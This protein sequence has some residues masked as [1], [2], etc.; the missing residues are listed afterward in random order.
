MN[1]RLALLATVDP[2]VTESEAFRLA[3]QQAVTE[4]GGWGGT[5]HLR[6]HRT[7]LRLVSTTGLPAEVTR[8]WEIIDPE[9]PAAPARAVRRG[10]GVWVPAGSAEPW[11]GTGLA[12][13]PLLS[14]GQAVG[15]LTVLTGEGAEPTPEHW[16]FLRATATWAQERMTGAP[17]PAGPRPAGPRGSRL[18]EALNEVRVGAWEWDIRT[19]ELSLDEAA[20]A[21]FG[22][23]T[24]STVPPVESW[25]R[26]VHP[27]DLPST[28]AVLEK[29]ITDGSLYEVEYRARRPDGGYGWTR[30]R[31]KVVPDR[32][33]EPVRMVGTVWDTT[34]SRSVRDTLSR[35]LRHMSDGFLA[36]DDDWQIVF[37]NREAERTLGSPEEELTGRTLW[38]L[39]AVRRVPD[40]ERRCREA[41]ADCAPAGFDILLP[42]TGRWYHLRLVPV[43]DG[44]T[45]YLTDVTEQRQREAEQQAAERA[46]AERAARIAELTTALAEATTSR[47][48]VDAVARRVLPPFGAAGL[49]VQTVEGDRVHNLGAVGHSQEF[50]DRLDGRPVAPG[51]PTA[52]AILADTP[53][54]LSSPEEFVARYPDMARY[55]D[56]AGRPGERGGQAWAFLPLTASGRPFGMCVIGFDG[57]RRLSGEERTLLTA[58]SGLVAQAL[59]RARLYDA[60]HTRAQELQRGLLPRELPVLPACT[61]AARYLPAGRGMEV[62]GDWYDVIPLSAGRV[63]LVIGDVMGHGLSEAATMGR[64]RTAVRTLADLELPPDEIMAHLNDVVGGLGEDS[65]ATCLYALYDPTSRS[66]SFTSAGHPP[67]AV[68]HPDG[69]LRFLPNT[70]NPPLGAADPPFETAELPLPDESLLVFYTDGLVESARRDIDAGLAELGSLLRT[71]GAE[72]AQNL[73][74]LCDTLTT[75]LLPAGQHATEDDAALLVV[76]VH[77]LPAEEM[78]SWSL[79]AEPQAAGQ[80]RRHVREQLAAWDLD[81]LVMTTELL[82]SELIGNVLRHAK[83]AP[84]L[85]LLRSGGL[86][87]EV[88]DSSVTMPHIRRAA[89]TDEGG[90]GLQLVAAL[91]R[92]WGTRYT[93]N[94]KCIWTEQALPGTADGGSGVDQLAAGAWEFDGDLDSLPFGDEG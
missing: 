78:A 28:L 12:A 91:S 79:P 20:A 58:I 33:G 64:L 56:V 60:E 88:Y 89:D 15:A 4:L 10:T 55:P 36:V 21:L 25:L 69:S 59:E 11:P 9:G 31:A 23:E 48:V 76:R 54:F 85:R 77:A 24:P 26:V 39:R 49:I 65:F 5:V 7:A 27:D 53:V 16:D 1:K 45:V 2:D 86:V 80:A 35:A 37:V 13:V 22:F 8:P 57:P 68:L 6:G 67:P 52:D 75:G 46:V 63:A 41:V 92:K 94:G 30:S 90:R 43:P 72:Q 34:E 18:R 19:R 38:E 66:C 84:R 3:L 17:P 51:T 93:G 61:A 71:S 73:D 81:D 14:G 83:G 62:G 47:D 29:A 74:P 42:D 87:C 82:A 32:S 50:L 70:P 44:T 40:L